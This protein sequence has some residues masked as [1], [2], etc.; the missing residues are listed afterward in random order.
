MRI[1]VVALPQVMPGCPGYKDHDR[2]LEGCLVTK[3]QRHRFG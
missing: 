3:I 2:G 1:L